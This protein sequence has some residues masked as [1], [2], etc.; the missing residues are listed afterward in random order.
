MSKSNKLPPGIRHNNP[1]NLKQTSPRTKWRGQVS[2][3]ALKQNVYEEFLTPEDG[4]RAMVRDLLVKYARGLDTVEK[5]IEVYAPRHVDNNQTD[6]YI[7]DVCQRM[8]KLLQRVVYDDTRLDL[9]DYN[10]THALVRAMV[11]HENGP[12][13]GADWYRD[14]VYIEALRRNNLT[15]STKQIVAKSTTIKT[16][17]FASVGGSVL[18]T[19]AVV[20][21][22]NQAK[23]AVSPGTYLYVALTLIVVACTLYIIY[24]R[25]RRAKIESQ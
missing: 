8:S 7:N 13:P 4:M 12:P 18:G 17:G 24:E 15:R 21:A 25:Y 6:A 23:D 20:D 11:R 10:T 9:D 3:I 2:D 14:E 16:A 19:T 22:V 1:G 5:I